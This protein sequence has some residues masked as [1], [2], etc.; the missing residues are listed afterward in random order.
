MGF[1]LSHILHILPIPLIYPILS[2]YN[3]VALT[4]SHS[5][6]SAG[7]GRTGTFIA[8]DML[9]RY[10]RGLME[11]GVK[12]G[13]YKIP[14]E[15][16]VYSNLTESGKSILLENRLTLSKVSASID[17]FKTV[18]WLRSQRLKSVQQD[19]SYNCDTL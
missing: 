4:F 6:C 12:N 11:D 13:G 18:L 2:F 8:I 19:V 10:I 15:E 3:Q 17:I 7:V 16:A 5:N 1:T 14:P 9:A